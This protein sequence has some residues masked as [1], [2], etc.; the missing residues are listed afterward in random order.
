MKNVL[1]SFFL[2]LQFICKILILNIRHLKNL[3]TSEMDEFLNKEYSPSQWT[4]RM[5]P[6]QVV[7]AHGDVLKSSK[8]NIQI[9]QIDQ[10]TYYC[11]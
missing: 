11:L 4:V 5:A 2:N 3:L 9:Q 1:L 6:D 8:S 7:L 10:L